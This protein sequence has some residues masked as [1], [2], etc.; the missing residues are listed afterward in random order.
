MDDLVF[1]VTFKIIFERKFIRCL[2]YVYS[3]NE[4]TTTWE[5]PR[6]V[7]QCRNSI[8][9]AISSPSP[10]NDLHSLAQQGKK[11]S[12]LTIINRTDSFLPRS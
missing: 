8:T 6:K 1:Y 4:K 3:H 7:N 5:D 11:F 9:A 12:F 2:Y 10:V